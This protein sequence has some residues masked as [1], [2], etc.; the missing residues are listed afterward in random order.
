M[1]DSGE[2]KHCSAKRGTKVDIGF[3]MTI[4]IDYG[5]L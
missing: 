4:L 2:C 3:H 1:K 5:M